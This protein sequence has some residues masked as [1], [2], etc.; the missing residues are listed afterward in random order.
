MLA[1]A[2]TLHL[3]GCRS[4][5]AG[6]PDPPTTRPADADAD[7]TAHADVTAAADAAEPPRDAA[8]AGFERRIEL[9]EARLQA[10]EGEVAELQRSLRAATRALVEQEREL[11]DLRGTP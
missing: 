2:L 4:D 7:V 9:L 1:L 11:A 6:L 8:V 3:G 5:D 10:R